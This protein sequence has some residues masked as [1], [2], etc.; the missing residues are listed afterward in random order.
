MTSQTQTGVLSIWKGSA[1]FDVEI[2]SGSIM[3]C[4]T[5]KQVTIIILRKGDKQNQKDKEKQLTDR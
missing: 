1:H 4:S 3:W 5:K 2:I